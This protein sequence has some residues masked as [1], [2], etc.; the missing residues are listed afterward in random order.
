MVQADRLVKQASYTVCGTPAA[1]TSPGQAD[2]ESQAPAPA[3]APMRGA[4]GLC[5]CPGQAALGA[6]AQAP[7]SS[8]NVLQELRNQVKHGGAMPRPRGVGQPEHSER[9]HSTNVL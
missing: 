8:T 1:S 3:A 6:L 9:Q 7:A 4:S 2:L 5:K